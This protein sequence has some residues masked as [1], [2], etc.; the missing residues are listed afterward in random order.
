M[1]HI[2]FSESEWFILKTGDNQ[3]VTYDTFKIY[4]ISCTPYQ[5][6]TKSGWLEGYRTR[7][8]DVIEKS[9]ST[10]M[11]EFKEICEDDDDCAYIEGKERFG[12]YK[13]DSATYFCENTGSLIIQSGNEKYFTDRCT[14]EFDS[15]S[16]TLMDHWIP[17]L[18]YDTNIDSQDKCF[19]KC[20]ER[21][22]DCSFYS[23]SQDMKQCGILL[24]DSSNNETATFC[25]RQGFS[26]I[27]KTCEHGHCRT[28]LP[29]EKT[30][31]CIEQFAFQ[32]TLLHNRNRR[33][34]KTEEDCRTHC[35][36]ESKN[37]TNSMC[38]Y[39]WF[40]SEEEVINVRSN[41]KKFELFSN[42]YFCFIKF[43]IT[44]VC[45]KED[46][47]TKNLNCKSEEIQAKV[48]SFNWEALTG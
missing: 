42:Q 23:W 30:K 45:S 34:A 16:C 18:K 35:E 14:N 46:W 19:K 33:R 21:G 26:T 12:T 43:D 9:S 28:I 13:K 29:S 38:Y 2:S 25:Q 7:I 8:S 22:E 40:E 3:S 31:G 6:L 48:S 36:N 37:E 39:T 4:S 20:E 17:S 5:S 44:K 24:K 11:M 15:E 10:T 1:T 32:D 27:N 41:S 47:V